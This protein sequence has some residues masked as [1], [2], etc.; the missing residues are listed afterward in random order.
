MGITIKI[1]PILSQ[2]AGD[3]DKVEVNGS[4]VGDCLND[5]V[6]QFPDIKKELF[7]KNGGLLHYISIWVN[8][9]DTYPAELAKQVRDGDELYLLPLFAGG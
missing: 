8:G 1:H 4:T 3:R 6:E 7:N 5:L 2:Y 9:A